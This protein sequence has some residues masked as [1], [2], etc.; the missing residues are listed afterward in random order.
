[1]TSDSQI[2]QAVMKFYSDLNQVTLV[3]ED[4]GFNM[5]FSLFD[6]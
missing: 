6:F 1:M 3:F 5:I 2:N 4:F